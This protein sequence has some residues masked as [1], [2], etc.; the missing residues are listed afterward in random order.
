V[1][2]DDAPD[3]VEIQPL[4]IADGDVAET[5]HLLEAIRQ[6]RIGA[7]ENLLAETVALHSDQTDMDAASQPW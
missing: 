6:R 1:P 4:V 5:H 7:R 3:D 2:G